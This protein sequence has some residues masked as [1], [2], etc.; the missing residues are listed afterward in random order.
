MIVVIITDDVNLPLDVDKRFAE[1]G[2][3]EF[4]FSRSANLQP[5][6]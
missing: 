3:V 4:I 5:G 6:S 2:A 1:N